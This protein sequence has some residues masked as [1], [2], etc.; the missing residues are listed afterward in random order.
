MK[1]LDRLRESAELADRQYRL[2]A[3]EMPTYLEMQDQ[4][5][6]ATAG[7]L[8]SIRDAHEHR[9]N[10]QLLTADPSLLP[11]TKPNGDQP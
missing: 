11:P 7:L 4:Y 5:M 10:I 9:L 3:V 2:G 8:G 6:E 1:M